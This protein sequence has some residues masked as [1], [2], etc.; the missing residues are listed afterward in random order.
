MRIATWNVN[1]IKQRADA[2]RN[3]L[4]AGHADVLCLQETKCEADAFPADVFKDIGFECAVVGQRAYNGVALL[5]K[6]G[7]TDVQEGLPGDDADEQAR[8]VQATVEGVRIG[9]LYLPN[10]NPP[11]D[12]AKYGYKLDWMRRLEA[13]AQRL[14][15]QG[16]PVVL[17]GD[18]NVIPT[19]NDCWDEAEWLDD[20]LYR[21]PTRQ[22]FRRI[23]NLGLTDA[24]RAVHPDKLSAYSFFDYQKGRWHR[25]EGIRID[26]LLLSPS[27]ADRLVDAGIDTEPR[28]KPKASDHTPV[29]CELAAAPPRPLLT[30]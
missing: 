3:W 27:A 29:W 30:P 5:S 22:A 8:Y 7:L 1:S 12:P 28:G 20:A 10:G 16:G 11:D 23:V 4:E 21:L 19:A 14:L 6:L 17:A 9:C 15:D 25:G 24:F 18:Y 26:H 13:H 2:V